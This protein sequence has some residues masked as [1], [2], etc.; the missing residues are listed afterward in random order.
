MRRDGS[1]QWACPDDYGRD[2]V[3]LSR[4]N[5]RAA[6]ALGRR[7][8]PKPQGI[9]YDG[10]VREPEAT[11]E[12]VLDDPLVRFGTR[13]F[14][15]WNAEH[16]TE[17]DPGVEWTL[18][19]LSG[20]GNS[21]TTPSE[22][23]TDAVLGKTVIPSPFATATVPAQTRK[24]G[25]SFWFTHKLSQIGFQAARFGGQFGQSGPVLLRTNDAGGIR[26]EFGTSAITP[27]VPVEWGAWH[28]YGAS[29]L[30]GGRCILT[31]DGVIVA[32]VAAQP[33]ATNITTLNLSAIGTATDSQY[34]AVY[35]IGTIDRAESLAQSRYM[36]QAAGLE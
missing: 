35:V 15:W 3:T 16:T 10:L 36:M 18:T 17:T 32:E 21:S 29:H 1:G 33:V 13:L 22:P 2:V 31:I 6:K 27:F 14:G 25:G 5:A 9:F 8:A 12:A 4:G 28:V 11:S 7:R 23:A 34:E 26:A 19:D 30:E 20:N 24:L